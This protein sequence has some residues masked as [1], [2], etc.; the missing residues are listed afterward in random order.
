MPI[1]K[2]VNGNGRLE[3]NV[4]TANHSS[5]C[6]YNVYAS[7]DYPVDINNP[8]NLIATRLT[9]NSLTVG[10]QSTYNYAVT[11]Q[12]RYGNESM[13]A[14]LQ[15]RPTPGLPS[16]ATAMP[17]VDKVL[18]LPKSSVID[19][20]YIAVETL[21]GQRV[22]YFLYSD[23]VLHVAHLP[24]GCYQWR[25]IGKKKRQHRLGFFTIKRQKPCP[26]SK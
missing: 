2:G 13:P 23:L 24:E 7:R 22:A 8:K 10:R 11:A 4:S 5:R 9:E 6:V 14:Q 21:Q 26:S 12:D 25:T 18:P 16:V 17:I 3:W 1:L 20:D 19:A 15:L